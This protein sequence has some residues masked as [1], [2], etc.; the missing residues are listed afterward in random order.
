MRDKMLIIIS[1][2]VGLVAAGGFY[3]FSGSSLFSGKTD[4][5]DMKPAPV[6]TVKCI[7]L[8]QDVP[9]RTQLTKEMLGEME[10][11][12]TVAHPQAVTEYEDAVGRVTRRALVKGEMLLEPHL[13]DG[14]APSNLSF[15]IPVGKRAITI[16]ASVTSALSNMLKPGDKVDVIVY[17]DKKVAGKEMSVTLLQD[18]MVLA[19]DAMIEEENDSDGI[20][21]KAGGSA[22]NAKGY[23]SVTL[24]ATPEDCVR[25]NLA[26]S[27]GR[28]KLTLDTPRNDRPGA[29]EFEVAV[30][31]D[32][33]RVNP[34]AVAEVKPVKHKTWR[35]AKPKVKTKNTNIE[36]KRVDTPRFT[37]EEKLVYIMR[38]TELEE[39]TVTEIVPV[40]YSAK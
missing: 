7:V 11:P 17:L 40:K 8:K 31:D 33:F 2:V 24:A 14:K 6:D 4:T 22:R 20:L 15:V 19:T 25:L 12:L 16:G 13:R 21:K 30:V 37:E 26:E 1:L 29:H 34:V 10:V 36:I 27:V 5:R 38:G 28:L 39:L 32:L 35:K 23:Q 18:M 9:K 3:L